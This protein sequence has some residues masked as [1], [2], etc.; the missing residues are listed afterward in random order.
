MAAFGGNEG[1]SGPGDTRA[2]SAAVRPCD[3]DGA[4]TPCFTPGTMIATPRG[5]VPVDLLR[6]GDRVMTRDAGMQEIRWI[7]RRHVGWPAMNANPHLRPILIRK[8]SLGEGLPERDMMVSPNHRMLVSNERTALYFA[9]AEVLVA[10]KHLVSG[11]SVTEVETAGVMYL[12]FLFDRHEV[13]LANGAWTESFQPTDWSLRGV[14]NSQRSE[15]LELFPELRRPD[16]KA[17]FTAA[18]RILSGAEAALAQVKSAG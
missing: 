14:G 6:V 8:G 16:A 7:G 18:R 10:A 5:E 1:A 2:V 12:H 17:S 9:E 3:R 13:V 15:I 11:R 4:V